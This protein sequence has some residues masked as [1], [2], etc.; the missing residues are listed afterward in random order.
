MRRLNEVLRN[1]KLEG[2]ASKSEAEDSTSRE[3]GAPA[4]PSADDERC[5]HCHDAGF[6]RQDLPLDHPEFGKAVPCRCVGEESHDVRLDRLQRYSNLG[7]LTRLTFDNLIRRGRS[8][9]PRD[10]ARFQRCVEDAEAFAKDP[11]GWL[12]LVGAS[13]CGKTHI[14]AAIANRCLEHGVPALFVVVPDL[15]DHLRAAYKPSAE[16]DYDQ[17]FEQVRITPVLILDDLGTQSATPWAQE[18]LFQIINHRFNARLPTVV[19]TNVPL[20][21]FD[22]RLR[23]RLGDPSLS[24]PHADPIAVVHTLEERRPQEYRELNMLEFSMIRDMTFE[25]FDLLDA[26]SQRDRNLRENA[27]RQALRYAD[28]PDGWMVFLG[29]RSRDRTHLIAAIGNQR[30]RF[31]ESPLLV[32]VQPLLDELRRAMFG[33]DTSDYYELKRQLRTCPLLLLDD[34]EIGMG[35]DRSRQELFQLLNPRYLAR[36]PTVITTPDSINRLLTDTGWERLARLLVGDADFCSV[37][38]IG[39]MSIEKVEA[40]APKRRRSPRQK[41]G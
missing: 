27:H 13:G 14:G 1:A 19:T 39:E 18:K 34:L 38:P 20:N 24:Q 4:A 3:E 28:K 31:G 6:V 26:R 21:K 9:D 16:V 5:P 41:S 17:L 40:V 10:Q 7:P 37:V 35:S 33:E 32:Q 8:A 15:L 30:R 12:V 36:L 22:D 29:N 23:T 11:E 25:S 2:E